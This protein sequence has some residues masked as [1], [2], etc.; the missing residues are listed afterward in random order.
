MKTDSTTVG[1]GS[2]FQVG[3]A[4]VEI[5]PAAG[6]QLAGDVAWRRPAHSILDPLFARAIVFAQQERRLC[7]L[8]LDVTFI[9]RAHT[10]II[11]KAAERMGFDPAAVLVHATQTH[12][13]PPIGHFLLDDEF[14]LAPEFQW[15]RLGDPGYS[16]MATERAIEA[17]RQASEFLKPAQLGTACA[18]RDGLAFNRRGVMRDGT[19]GM[20]WTYSSVDRPLGA[21]E[22]RYLEGPT[23]PEIGVLCVRD[24]SLHMAA[25][26]LHFT[27]HPVN[28]FFY[29]GKGSRPRVSA[30]WPG[31]WGAALQAVHGSS[32][33][34]LVLNGCCGN[35]NPWPPFVPDFVP[36]HRRMGGILADIADRV[37]ASMDFR[38][39]AILDYASKSVPLP[40]RAIDADRLQ[41]ARDMLTR[42]P[43]PLGVNDQPDRVEWEWFHSAMMVS[44]ELERQREPE[45]AYEIQVLRVGDNAFVGLPGEPF[46]E[47]QLQIK[48]NSPAYPT[49]VAHACNHFAGYIPTRDA[50]ARGGHEVNPSSWSRLAPEALDIITKESTGML[51]ELFRS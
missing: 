8:G 39:D 2:S 22:Y 32:C 37:I 44:L 3:A 33:V 36:D 31:A 51:K 50:F 34:P 1:S 35:I 24:E 12:S 46:V 28:D 27:C 40:L 48:L 30:D 23:D 45:M 16:A 49:F 21:T 7:F 42:H 41:A 20:P 6:V 38:S 10:A 19:V 17:L 29:R 9:D 18:I 14:P 43:A 13:A 4:M 11:R 5:S 47:G 15:L 26:L 25:M